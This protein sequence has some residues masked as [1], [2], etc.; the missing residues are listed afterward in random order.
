[1]DKNESAERGDPA[2]DQR[3]FR[4]CLSQF[5]TGVTVITAQAAEERAG[6][7]ANSFAS[8]SLDPALVTWAIKR[9]SRSCDVFR[10]A[11]H[12]AVNVLADDQIEVSRTFAMPGLD[13]FEQ[14]RWS[15]GQDGAPLIENV[16]AT[17][18]CDTETVHEGGD[19]L[20]IVGRVRRFCRYE[21]APL[22][23]VQGRYG[24]AV[25]HPDLKPMPDAGSAAMV[26]QDTSLMV[27]TLIAYQAMSQKFETRRRSVGM[28][29][30]QSRVLAVLHQSPDGVKR[31]SLAARTY[32]GTR[33]AE[34]AVDDLVERGYV[35]LA[36]AN[37]MLTPRGRE[38]RD[39]ILRH[40]QDFNL[41]QVSAFS[42]DEVETVRRVLTHL[43]R[44][45]SQAQ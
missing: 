10:H 40:L 21:R 28:S 18:E 33:D 12:F 30:P 23:F 43:I 4:R 2:I 45:N 19:H 25:D 36:G 3:A 5:G 11:G 1:M 39:A 22:L 26:T 38:S 37:M 20:L 7:T 41:E 13:K 9:D 35:Q 31:S 34:D 17:F 24:V 15:A 6:V 27:L 44:T 42:S 8:L 14:V 29:L 16:L 32:L